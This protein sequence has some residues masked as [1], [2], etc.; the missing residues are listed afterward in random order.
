M[1]VLF[2]LLIPPKTLVCWS[3]FSVGLLAGLK[4]NNYDLNLYKWT[5]SN[6]ACLEELC[7]PTL[8]LRRHYLT[9]IMI[10]SILRMQ[11]PI[12]PTSYFKFNTCDTRSHSL[13]LCT[14]HSTINAFRY[15]FYINAPFL[16]NQVPYDV[17]SLPPKSFGLKLCLH[18]FL[19][20]VF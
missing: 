17:L 13:T 18:L 3:L 5:K 2:G 1:G 6:D 8:E 15:S 20:I 11:T 14:S 12:N 7:W 4:A 10:H 9:I 16:W 19:N